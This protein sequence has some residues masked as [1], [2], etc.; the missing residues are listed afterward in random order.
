M[1]A[2]PQPARPLRCGQATDRITLL[3]GAINAFRRLNVGLQVRRAGSS[4]RK[5]A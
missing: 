1:T 2:P 4:I 3:I 5:A